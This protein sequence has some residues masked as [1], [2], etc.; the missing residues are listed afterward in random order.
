MFT[1]EEVAAQAGKRIRIEGFVLAV[2]LQSKISF[3]VFGSGASR[4]QAVCTGLAKDQAKGLSYQSYAAIEGKVVESAQAPGGFELLADIVELISKAVQWPVAEDS[5]I[6]H[7]LEWPVARFRERKEALSQI[8]QSQLEFHMMSF[9]QQRGFIGTHTPKLMATPSESGA[10]VFE[11]KYFGEK[12]YLAQS[13]QFYK[14]ALILAGFGK[15]Y[16]SA[17]AFRAEPSFS[18]RHATEFV[19]FDV[20]LE[21]V[22]SETDLVALECDMLRAAMSKTIDVMGP[23]LVAHFP[24]AKLPGPEMVLTFVQAQAMLGIAGDQALTAEEERRLGAMLGAQGVELLAL[25]Q[26]PWKQR[27]F[28]HMRD[29]ETLTKSFE[30][31]YRGVEITTGAIREHRYDV[32]MGQLAD[33]G[34]AGTGMEFHLE[35]FKLGAPPHGGFGL[36]LQRLVMLFL[37]LPGIKEASFIHRGPG[38]L[39]P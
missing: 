29:G 26:V 14:Q 10:E 39:A 28:Y 16:E 8:V 2:R 38:R 17:P 7:K 13:P 11:V 34:L 25:I 6:G 9:L 19:S 31:L 18:S 35:S 23:E 27:P 21:G 36:G 30:L 32:L 4:I 33:K 15:V 37:R 1:F 24:Q 20:E 22:R 3:V 5:E 12:A